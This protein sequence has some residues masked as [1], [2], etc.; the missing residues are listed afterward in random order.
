MLPVALA[1]VEAIHGRR[2][3]RPITVGVYV[4][5]EAFAAANGTGL[6]GA[7]GL[8]FLGRV[9]LSPTLFSA[10]RQRLPAILTHEL[11]HAHLRNWISELDYIRLPHWFREGLTVMVF[12]GGRAEGVSEKGA[13]ARVESGGPGSDSGLG[14]CG[15]GATADQHHKCDFSVDVLFL[16]RKSHRPNSPGRAILLN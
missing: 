2:F 12:G 15:S 8:T 10:H 14:G 5:P 9:I 1:R 11:S 13:T 3:A 16:S 7:V 4:S 6:S